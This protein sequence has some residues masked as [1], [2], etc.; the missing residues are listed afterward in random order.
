MKPN[1]D[2]A[3]NEKSVDSRV[4]SRDKYVWFLA[5]LYPLL[6]YVFI[7]ILTY[8]LHIELLSIFALYLMPSIAICYFDRQYLIDHDLNKPKHWYIYIPP[9]YL[10]DSSK[11]LSSR[12]RYAEDWIVS[13][14]ALLL[15]VNFLVYGSDKRVNDGYCNVVTD[16]I[17]ENISS[18]AATCV[19][20][21]IDHEVTD[22]LYAATA[23]LSNGKKIDITITDQGDD[24]YIEL[25]DNVFSFANQASATPQSK[26]V[27]AWQPSKKVPT[28][29]ELYGRNQDDEE[30]VR[31]DNR[32]SLLYEDGDIELN[33]HAEKLNNSNV[34]TNPNTLPG[35]EYYEGEDSGVVEGM[36]HDYSDPYYT[37]R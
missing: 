30:S 28:T 3:S 23:I 13:V 12:K 26:P 36:G 37:D 17:A 7:A 15:V 21:N 5:K 32:H 4:K 10:W 9:L 24:Y 1:L 16:I 6:M 8:N 34:P 11:K 35:E 33:E 18:S 20:V 31:D 29:D 14:I 19:K 2:K 25:V 27:E 22:E